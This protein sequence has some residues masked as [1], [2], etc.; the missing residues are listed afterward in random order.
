MNH[1]RATQIK[2]PPHEAGGFTLIELMITVAIVGILAAVAYP[3]Y[4]DQ[5]RKSR[6]NAAQAAMLEIAQK[7]MQLFLDTRSYVAAASAA[8]LAGAPLRVAVESKVL[9][10]YDL[11]VA[12]TDTPPTFTV[13]ATPKGSQTAERCGT[14]TVTHLGAKTPATGCW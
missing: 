2:P 12:A 1:E 5:V 9:D 7:E 11:A 4:Q 10:Y 6:R 8:A 14:L 13:T 3:S